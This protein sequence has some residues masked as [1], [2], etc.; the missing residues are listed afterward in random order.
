MSWRRWAAA[1]GF[2]L[3]GGA[4]FY[5]WW[6]EEPVFRARITARELTL[7]GLDKPA[8]AHAGT[9]APAT[10]TFDIDAELLAGT[11][12]L[13]LNDAAIPWTPAEGT[14]LHRHLSLELPVRADCGALELIASDEDGGGTRLTIG[15]SPPTDAKAPCG[16]ALATP[17]SE[18]SHRSLAPTD[19]LAFIYKTSDTGN[20]ARVLSRLNMRSLSSP[21]LTEDVR[22]FDTG[23]ERGG[24]AC[25]G[26]SIRLEANR[27]WLGR[28]DLHPS[29]G[30]R[31]HPVLVAQ[32]YT[33]SYAEVTTLKPG[34]ESRCLGRHTGRRWVRL[35]ALISATLS[36]LFL[37][38][39]RF[40]RKQSYRGEGTE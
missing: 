31:R 17:S 25:L 34:I 16:W 6:V 28:L 2:V 4:I 27:L 13:Q 22:P 8:A 7:A 30:E 38:L 18:P 11:V 33:E 35:V 37:L 3:T 23:E 32:T 39:D 12:A 36:A 19:Q 14:G 20:G 24:E 9:P 1:A 21:Q 10:R 15:R 26:D 5:L 29:N 40:K